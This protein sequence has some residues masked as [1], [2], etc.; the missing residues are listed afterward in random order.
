MSRLANCTNRPKVIKALQRAGFQVHAGGKHA[1]IT[2][3][4]GNFLSVIPNARQLNPYTLKAILKQVRLS[5]DEFV[6]QY[7]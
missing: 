1:I 4:E 2:D 6:K 7:R 3:A 5:E